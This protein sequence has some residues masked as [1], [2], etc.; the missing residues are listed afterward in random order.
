LY[1]CV[2][3]LAPILLKRWRNN[4]EAVVETVNN[5]APSATVSLEQIGTAME[6]AA[7]AH[8]E[9][10]PDDPEQ[11]WTYNYTK[12]RL[13]SYTAMNDSIRNMAGGL[14]KKISS[15]HLGDFIRS[16]LRNLKPIETFPP[17]IVP[18]YEPRVVSPRPIT[19]KFYV[20]DDEKRPV[21]IEFEDNDEIF[22]ALE[23]ES[24]SDISETAASPDSPHA[25]PVS[26]KHV[27]IEEK[28]EDDDLDSE[29][30]RAPPTTAQKII[31]LW[32]LFIDLIEWHE[33]SW[34][35]SIVYY[36]FTL[37]ATYHILLDQ[38]VHQINSKF[39]N[40]KSR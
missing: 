15:G 27:R 16:S 29:T 38:V 17:P 30:L 20:T 9:P 1:V 6:R 32:Y 24:D 23:I 31:G 5:A 7:I 26:Q 34:F 13:S 18:E 19:L 14:Q 35:V 3:I 36:D 21:H 37:L 4:Q 11:D 12:E 10:D 40:T 2:V 25:L 33:M 22:S 28:D 39:D 8:D